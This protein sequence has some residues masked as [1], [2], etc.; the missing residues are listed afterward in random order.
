M[1]TKKTTKKKAA[2]KKHET[3]KVTVDPGI[4]C[5]HCQHKYDHKVLNT[6]PNGKRRRAC[7]GCGKPF[8]SMI[9]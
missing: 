9:E 8:I 4:K 5:P 1:P 3:N 7:G 6:Y 2:R